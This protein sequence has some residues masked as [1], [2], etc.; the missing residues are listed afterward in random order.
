MVSLRNDG[1][2]D[3]LFFWEFYAICCHSNWSKSKIR[4][5][6]TVSC[7]CKLFSFECIIMY[8]RCVQSKINFHVLVQRFY[9]TFHHFGSVDIEFRLFVWILENVQLIGQCF[10]YVN[11]DLIDEIYDFPGKKIDFIF[12][13]EYKRKRLVV[14]ISPLQLFRHR[15]LNYRSFFK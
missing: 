8:R 6:L 4:T 7:N 5:N 10:W 14:I 13:V 15:R 2:S 11:G 9:A 1:R 12:M 3:R